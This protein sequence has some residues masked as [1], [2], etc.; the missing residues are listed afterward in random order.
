MHVDLS[1]EVVSI[2]YSTFFSIPFENMHAGINLHARS[3]I[4]TL[5]IRFSQN[6]YL[7]TSF[8]LAMGSFS[9]AELLKIDDIEDEGECCRP[10]SR[11]WNNFMTKFRSHKISNN[12]CMNFDMSP[13]S[14][15]LYFQKHFFSFSQTHFSRNNR[16][17]KGNQDLM[18]CGEK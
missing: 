16:I 3:K 11:L 8:L 6:S 7:M 10:A 5:L 18:E 1:Q 4:S 9:F 12:I 15:S 17:N 14:H 2:I 13:V